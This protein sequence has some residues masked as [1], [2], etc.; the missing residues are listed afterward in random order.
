[1]LKY[2]NINTRGLLVYQLFVLIPGKA[3]L[4]CNFWR[5]AT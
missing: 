3:P 4:K 2:N 1:M 5:R